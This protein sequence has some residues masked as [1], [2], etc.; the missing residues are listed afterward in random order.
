MCREYSKRTFDFYLLFGSAIVE[1]M[2]K[3]FLRFFARSLLNFSTPQPSGRSKSDPISQRERKNLY[4]RT[5]FFF[6]LFLSLR[7]IAERKEEGKERFHRDQ[8]NET[9]S[10]WKRG[11]KDR[12]ALFSVGLFRARWWPNDGSSVSVSATLV[13]CTFAREETACSR[14]PLQIYIRIPLL[15]YPSLDLMPVRARAFER[16]VVSAAR[17]DQSVLHVLHARTI[18]AGNPSL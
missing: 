10:D 13:P 17:D 14:H 16:R 15:L 11:D 18:A 2:E 12:E 1:V 7:L 9:E 4:I 8:N 5:L 6:P 3:N